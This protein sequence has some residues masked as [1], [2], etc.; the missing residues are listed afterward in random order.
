ME[1]TKFQEWF[2]TRY[3]DGGFALKA[4]Y[5]Y[6]DISTFRQLPVESQIKNLTAWMEA[7]FEAGQ[8][9]MVQDDN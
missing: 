8:Q 7:A 4:E 9:S 1:Y 2:F 3:A 6:E 5:F